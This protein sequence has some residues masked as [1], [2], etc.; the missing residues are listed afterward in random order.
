MT[1][2]INTQQSNNQKSTHTIEINKISKN[3]IPMNTKHFSTYENS[4]RNIFK[5]MLNS[6]NKGVFMDGI[7][8]TDLKIWMNC[9]D[10][11]ALSIRESIIPGENRG[12]TT[13]RN[14]ISIPTSI[15]TKSSTVR[16]IRLL[17]LWHRMR[18]DF[19]RLGFNLRIKSDS[20][21]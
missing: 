4:K 17:I 3:L 8:T 6:K 18:K 15:I 16:K 7:N 21:H 11:I 19:G 20:Q 1:G 9:T 5:S 13:A 10:T 12:R 2:K 14:I